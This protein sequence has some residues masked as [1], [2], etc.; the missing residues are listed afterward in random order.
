MQILIT[1]GAG[2][3]GTNTAERFLPSASKITILDNFHRPT[4]RGNAAYLAQLSPKINIVE[5][6]VLD[7]KLLAKLVAKADVVIHL[8]AQVAVTT[9]LTN[10]QEDFEINVRGTF[11]VL[12][13]VRKHRPGAILLY[14]S[15]NKVYGDLADVSI[16]LKKGIAESTPIDLYS[17]Y[18]CSKGAADLYCLDYARS[19]GL[20][21]VVF[22]QSCIYGEHQYGVEDQGWLAFFVLQNLKKAPITIY[23]SGEQIRDMLQVRDLTQ[24]YQLAVE[25]IDL[26]KGQVFN[27]GGG[28]KNAISINQALADIAERVGYATQLSRAEKRLGDQDYFV[29]DVS[30][31]KKVF[32]WQPT[33]GYKAGLT[34]LVDWCRQVV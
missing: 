9:S 7:E 16:N 23:G 8:A 12:E 20:K 17:P 2:F 33:I 29:A 19:F 4:S 13:A 18:G 25:K 22:R 28:V 30:K 27:V 31:A 11:T 26:A 34:G 10:P 21:T 24:L 1:G 32:G 5:G 14:S 3:I 15:T 6:S